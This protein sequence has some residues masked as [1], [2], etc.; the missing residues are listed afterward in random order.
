M[1]DCGCNYSLGEDVTDQADTQVHTDRGRPCVTD[2]TGTQVHAERGWPAELMVVPSDKYLCNICGYILH[3][4]VQTE[5]GH[6]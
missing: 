1:A 6:R 4:G 3:N 5:C 2:Q